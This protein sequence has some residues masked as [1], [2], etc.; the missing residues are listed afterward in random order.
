MRVTVSGRRGAGSLGA[1]LWPRRASDPGAC[2]RGPEDEEGQRAV[3]SEGGARREEGLVTEASGR[4]GGTASTSSS[5]GL[6][7]TGQEGVGGWGG[8]HQRVWDGSSG[9]DFTLSCS[10][11]F[12][13]IAFALYLV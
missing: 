7:E 4:L 11:L 3:G 1:A 12:V 6:E 10:R 9:T 13:I 8:S 5:H 2:Q